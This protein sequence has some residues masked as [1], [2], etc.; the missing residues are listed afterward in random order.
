MKKFLFIFYLSFLPFFVFAQSPSFAQRIVIERAV[1]IGEVICEENEGYF[2]CKKPYDQK[3]AGVIGENP[4]FVFGKPKEKSA[5]L[6]FLGTA[7]VKV[8]NENGEIK[9]GD[10]LT[11]SSREGFAQKATISGYVLGR[12]LEDFSGKEGKI[13]AQIN[14]QYQQIQ[15]P[16]ESRVSLLVLLKKIVE[17]MGKGENFPQTLRYVFAVVLAGISFLFGFLYFGRILREE[18]AAVGRNPLAKGS[19]RMVTILNLIGIAILTL[20]G[21]GL[22][23]F[24]ILY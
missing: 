8:C 7:L 11:S 13:L 24:V 22:A 18:I 16:E 3:I 20:A 5:N 4:V 17:Q 15:G 6:I 21:L 9:K 23:L 14:I 1:E 19:I 2:P 10:F 12:A